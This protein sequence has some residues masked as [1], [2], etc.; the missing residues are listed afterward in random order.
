LKGGVSDIA[1]LK[2]FCRHSL[3]NRKDSERFLNGAEVIVKPPV[4][5]LHKKFPTFYG[6]RRFTAIF[7]RALHWSYPEPYQSSP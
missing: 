6:N 7:T 3:G 4:L 2:V 5:Q 1:S